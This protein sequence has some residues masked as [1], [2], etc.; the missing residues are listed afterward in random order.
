[1]TDRISTRMDLHIEIINI[2]IIINQVKVVVTL[3]LHN[4][5]IELLKENK[6]HMI[7][8]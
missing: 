1:M 3:N 4:L 8:Y 5:S 6:I 2:I 7:E